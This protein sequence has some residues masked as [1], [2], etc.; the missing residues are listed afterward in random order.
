M[1]LP[2]RSTG[3]LLRDIP[4]GKINVTDVLAVE[5]ACI[6]THGDGSRG[7]SV[8]AATVKP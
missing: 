4:P 7:V 6:D 5:C 2:G 3:R 8:G 1:C